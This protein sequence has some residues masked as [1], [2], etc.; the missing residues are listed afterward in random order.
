MQV[1]EIFF[2][3]KG[4]PV[5]GSMWDRIPL[6]MDEFETLRD[7]GTVF[8]S[9]GVWSNTSFTLDDPARVGAR[10]TARDEGERVD[11][12]RIGRTCRAR[13]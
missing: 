6:G 8:S 11:A 4:N 2:D 1:R 12:R 9:I 3:W 7:K 5:F 10:G 13:A